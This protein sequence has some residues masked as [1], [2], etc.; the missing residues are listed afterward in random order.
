M[1][2]NSRE[3]G[4]GN[5]M[6]TMP[7]IQP[8]GKPTRGSVTV[9]EPVG[10]EETGGATVEQPEPAHPVAERVTVGERD[11]PPIDEP[12]RRDTPRA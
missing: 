10:P 6:P 12:T 2:C 8:Q 9:K 5:R 4:I 1:G 7:G 3:V 11:G